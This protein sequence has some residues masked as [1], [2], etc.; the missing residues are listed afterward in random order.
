MEE[1][2]A[3]LRRLGWPVGSLS[4]EEIASHLA[5]KW[6]ARTGLRQDQV[7]PGGL[8]PALGILA[9][10]A[11][12]GNLD[13]LCWSADDEVPEA[14]RDGGEFGALG[15]RSKQGRPG[16][17]PVEPDRRSSRRGP[18][19]DLIDFVDTDSSEAAT[20]FLVD[21]SAT[22]LAFIA[23]TTNAPSVGARIA[24]TIHRRRGG[25]TELGCAIVVRTE[26]LSDVLSLVCA[27]LDET[28]EP[29][30]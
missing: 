5:D 24:P 14:E 26:L 6:Y 17:E 11:N 29:D 12:E 22:G 9:A 15:I 10:M 16:S 27:R 7:R 8:A 28:W 25:T 23:E 3:I 4:D 30:L 13:A 2:R 20:G 18:A 21:V 19:R 1:L